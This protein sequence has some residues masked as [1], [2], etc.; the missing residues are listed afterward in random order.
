MGGH[1]SPERAF[2][3]LH[4]SGGEDV[5]GCHRWTGLKPITLEE[6]ADYRTW[7]RRYDLR[8]RDL[9]AT[10]GG[11]REGFCWVS[12]YDHEYDWGIKLIVERLAMMGVL[13]G[14]AIVLHAPRPQE[15]AIDGFW[16]LMEKNL[17][18]LAK[19]AR[20]FGVRIA[21]ENTDPFP[22]NVDVL[23][24][25][26]AMSDPDWIGCCFDSGHGRI[27]E[28]DGRGLDF[29]AEIVAMGRL[30]ALHLHDNVGRHRSY[31]DPD[32]HLIPFDP[33]VGKKGVNWRRFAQILA[34][35]SY[36]GPI[37]LE[38]SMTM[39][40]DQHPGYTLTPPEFLKQSLEAGRQLAAMVAA[41]RA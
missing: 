4:E 36:T 39:Y 23:R 3:L 20:K 5:H 15:A 30:F 10:D 31:P 1:G 28:K 13:G 16:P 34:A 2:R 17:E 12:T 40:N 6:V 11:P 33:R 24:R 19:K 32:I 37:T 18:F 8:M 14:E 27:H 35:S 25:M 21:L 22:S 29:L 38:V 9:H 7:L 26:L 41:H